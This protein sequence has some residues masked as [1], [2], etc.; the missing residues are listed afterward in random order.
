MLNRSN[1]QTAFKLSGLLFSYCLYF[2]VLDAQAPDQFISSPNKKIIVRCNVQKLTYSIDY[3]GENIIKDSRLGIIREDE[4][5]SK[6]LVLVK[7]GSP[8]TVKD[9]YNI[10]T[11]K[12]K[13]IVYLAN[14]RVLQAQTGSGKKMNIV[15]Q[16]SNDG[17]AF[18]YEFPERSME[19]KKIAREM[20]SFHFNDNTKAWLQPKTEAQS[21]WE[22]TNPSYEAHYR[23]DI[24]A[25]TPSPTKNGWVYPALFYYNNV[26]ILITE[27][28]LGRG[29]C[30]TALQQYAPGNEYSIGFPQPPEAFTNGALDPQSTLPWQTPW[31]IIAIGNLK[32]IAESTLGTDVAFPAKKMDASFIRPGKASWSW[33]QKKDD[34]IV[35]SVQ[36]HYI[37]FAA[38]MKWQYC[39]IDAN[40]DTKIGYDSIQLLAD[41][42]AKKN[43]GLLLWYNSAGGWNTVKYHPKDKLL[44]HEDRIKEFARLHA[45][46]IKGVK[47]D[48]FAGDGQSMINYYQ[49][50]LEDAAVNKLL[51]NFHGAT[52]PRGWQRTYPNLMTTEAV[53]GYEMITFNQADADQAPGHIVMCAFARNAFDPMDFTPMCLY[54]IPRINRVTTPGFELAT[55]VILLSGIQ[56]YAESPEGMTHVPGFVQTFLQDL[57]SSWDDVHFID[58][59]PGKFMIVARKKGTKWYIAGINGEASEK[60]WEIDVSFIGQKRIHLI[61]DD[62]SHFFDR[63]NV[64]PTNGK[65]EITVKPNG[66]FVGVV[67][68]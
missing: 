31:R 5:F 28:A 23:M 10:L 13:H 68:Q 60:K 2:N 34:S 38:S 16:V 67:D 21:G 18:R 22:H 3:N 50:I 32:T 42:G 12:K 43:V 44:N 64:T 51:V 27:A 53:Y 33:I 62:D 26:W 61:T 8:V 40:W 58:G 54:K 57:P 25:G 45:I 63:S 39:L 66:G 46:G 15:F 55:S 29:Y 17:V 14:K 7:A 36:K 37:D 59:Y 9:D 47:I 52:L 24:P 48:F 65:I 49:D 56:H 4:D 20:T 1:R 35:Y 30:G 41:Y 11:A 6:D 19:I